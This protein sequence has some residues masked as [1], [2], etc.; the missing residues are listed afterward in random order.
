MPAGAKID[1]L[2]DR[3][4]TIRS[5]VN[6]VQISLLISIRARGHGHLPVSAA[7]LADLHRE[8]YRAAGA[9]RTIA[10]MYLLGY[11]IDNL[12]LMAITI[13]VGFVVDDAI[14]V[15]ENIHRF[16]EQGDPPV[17]AAFGARGRSASRSFDEPVPD[18]RVHSVAVH[19]RLMAVVSRIR[20]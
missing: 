19:E 6:D 16:I 12:S 9:L 20:R 4:T 17:R 11:S 3:T 8:L 14:V 18:R 15:I 5:S 2:S 13:S 1:V 10:M 7:I